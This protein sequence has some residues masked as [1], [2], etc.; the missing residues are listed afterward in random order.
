MSKRKLS[1]AGESWDDFKQGLLTEEERDEIE[2]RAK[3]V[4]EI[5]HSRKENGL[6]QVGLGSLCGVKQPVIARMEKGTTDPQLTTVLKVLRAL[7]KTLEVVDL[8]T[9][10]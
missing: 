9:D 3:I 6:T 8:R 4:S 7:G 1:S 10:K 2:L 5:I